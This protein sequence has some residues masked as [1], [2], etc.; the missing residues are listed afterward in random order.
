[1]ILHLLPVAQR[2]SVVLRYR[3]ELFDLQKFC[4]RRLSRGHVGPAL[5]NGINHEFR[6]IRQ[7]GLLVNVM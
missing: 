1:M 5:A 6:T 4:N 2:R 7:A 3:L